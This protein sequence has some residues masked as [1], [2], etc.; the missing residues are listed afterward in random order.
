[1]DSAALF[2]LVTAVIFLSSFIRAFLG[3]GDALV[4][5]P[6]LAVLIGIKSATPLVAFC[7]TTS[8]VTILIKSW[9]KADIK[10][11]VRLVLS[12]IAG[13]PFG[14][15]FI[16]R[17]PEGYLK[18]VLGLILILYGLYSLNR[19]RFQL[20]KD[21]A[22]VSW[23]FGLTAG[24]LGGAYNTNGPPI[25]IYASLRRWPPEHFQAT[26][27]SYFLPTGLLVLTGHGLAGLWTVRIL[28]FYLV[29][30]PLVLLAV[31][32]GRKVH[33]SLKPGQFNTYVH[34]FL[35]GMGLLLI[36]RSGLL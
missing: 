35:V 13:I 36:L 15:I 26:L 4:A 14:L 28:R 27:Q 12:T 5:M 19:P 7:S 16:T 32:L 17:V 10:A 29:A 20:K 31:Y 33:R 11:T 24:V 23:V 34:A 3:F 2:I 18:L 22:P 1:M 21:S 30:L 25:V 9:R 6:I 8:A